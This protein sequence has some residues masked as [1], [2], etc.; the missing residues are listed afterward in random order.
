MDSEPTTKLPRTVLGLILGVAFISLGV[1]YLIIFITGHLKEIGVSAATIGLLIGVFGL[2]PSLVAIPL[3]IISD[4]KGRKWPLIL[5]SLGVGPSMIVFAL[6]TELSYLLLSAVLLGLAEA[7]SL[8]TWN[9]IIADQTNLHNRDRAFSLS[10]IVGNLFTGIGLAIPYAFP[11]LQ[12]M[13][14]IDSA[15]IYRDFMIFFSLLSLMTPA[16]FF[17]LLRGYA[18]VNRSIGPKQ[19]SGRD[20]RLLAKFS[21]FN[22]LIGLGAGFIIPL[23]PTWLLLKF[24]VTPQYS[25]PL[26]AVSNI[27]IAFSSIG[28]A[29]IAKVYGPV[30]SIVLTTGASTIFMLSLAYVPDPLLAAGLYIIRAGLMNMAGPLLDS[31][32]MGI[33]S[34]EQRGLASAINSI[35]WRLPNSISTVVGGILL[36]QGRF[37][38][39]F[40]LATGFYVTAISLF[41]WNFRNI[42]PRT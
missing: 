42:R 10:F 18:E 13:L 2:V 22:G 41:Y 5:G 4:R 35:V 38:V 12:R 17:V 32:L 37:D 30:R 28:S 15:T 21:G 11:T 20:M 16:A 33:I 23:I 36:D 19:K 26:L 9:A 29:R 24:A 8:A 25:G 7:A 34:A 6:T 3:G 14:S 27:T 39:P 31:Y 40:L 1:G